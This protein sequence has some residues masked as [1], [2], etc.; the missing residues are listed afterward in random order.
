MTNAQ[1]MKV[2]SEANHVGFFGNDN[3]ETAEI[4]MSS[5]V[6]AHIE[7]DGSYIKLGFDG[8]GHGTH[9][10]GIVGANGKLSGVAPGVQIISLKA[11]GSSGDGGWDAISN[12]MEYAASKGADIINISIGSVFDSGSDMS[13]QAQKINY[14]ASRYNV[15]F[16]FAAGNDGP[17]IG[18]NISPTN[19]DAAIITGA[20][21]SPEIWNLNYGCS[22][23]EEGLWYFSAAGPGSD[24]SLIP[25]V[26]A[27]GSAVSAVNIWDSGGYYLLDGT[28]MA[29]PHVSGAAAL[30]INQAR[31][32]GI[33]YN[34]ETVKNAIEM[35]ARPL[36]GYSAIEQGYGLINVKKS[37]Q[38]LRRSAN[39]PK[40]SVSAFNP[41]TKK[42][43]GIYFRGT[44]PKEIY[45][46]V[47]NLSNKEPVILKLKPSEPWIKSDRENLVLPK[48]KSRDI[49]LD[50]QIPDEPG[51]YSTMLIGDD[52]N[53]YGADLKIPVTIINPIK[54]NKYNNYLYSTQDS[55]KP[56]KWKRYFFSIPPNMKQ[57]RA[58]IQ[59]PEEFDLPKGR[60]RM[61]IID[62][63]G[64]EI[65]QTE[66]VGLDGI[67]NT[68][69]TE[70]VIPEP[71][72]GVWEAVVY[73]DPYLADYGLDS[74]TYTL[75]IE[76]QGIIWGDS[77]LDII[78]PEGENIKSVHQELEMTNHFRDFNSRLYG[79]GFADIKKGITRQSFEVYEGKVTAGL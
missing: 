75:T 24:G 62:P 2:Y 15:I 38:H 7:P 21:I 25:N 49:K 77:F 63:R 36:K 14:L 20:Y 27:P 45:I 54:F 18:S 31:K 44:I 41:L 66:Y 70:I 16:V 4:E 65:I 33:K 51:L 74:S 56:S 53:T 79:M 22:V 64:R 3:P 46:S 72:E 1:P 55:L 52:T 19:I 30:L 39:I 59:I 68:D 32:E 60:V 42:G 50:F 10:A 71:I 67:N 34:Y 40:L 26:I 35:G 8:N 57:F 28:S 13:V 12:A 61:H 29:A 11:M 78:I 17:G 23:K 48:G 6:V 73:C 9:V 37:L 43:S 5:F 58:E 76:P 69:K 47:T